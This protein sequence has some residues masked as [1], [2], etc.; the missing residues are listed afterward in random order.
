MTAEYIPKIRISI[1]AI[2][3]SNL[4][5]FQPRCSR[6]VLTQGSRPASRVGEGGQG[7]AQS[8]GVGEGVYSL[9]RAVLGRGRQ[10]G[11]TPGHV[12]SQSK[13]LGPS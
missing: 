10:K 4:G 13:L 1:S 9:G 2:I 12:Y 8:R 7:R 6:Q 5:I 11:P 3:P